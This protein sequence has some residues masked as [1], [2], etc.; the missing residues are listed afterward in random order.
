[1]V[2]TILG[3]L[4]YRRKVGEVLDPSRESLKRLLEIKQVTGECNFTSQYQ[5]NQLPSAE[6][7]SKPSG[8]NTMIQPD[9]AAVHSGASKLGHGKQEWR[10]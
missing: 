6:P 9:P 8:C 4:V 5:E 3:T 2:E 1:M 7:W 10:S